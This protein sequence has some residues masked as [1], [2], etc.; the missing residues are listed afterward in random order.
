MASASPNAN[1]NNVEVVGAR[2][3]GQASRACGNGS[4]MSASLPNV[5]DGTEVMAMS[6]T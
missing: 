6:G 2:P 1:C 4:T 3:F 5:L